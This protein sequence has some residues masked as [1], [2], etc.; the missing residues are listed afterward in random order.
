MTQQR[1]TGIAVKQQDLLLLMLKKAGLTKRE[2]YDS[3][4]RRWV[5]ANL[6][7]LNSDERRQ[8]ADVLAL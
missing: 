4:E 7:L 1:R 6:D 5:N 2:I 8:Y 3:A